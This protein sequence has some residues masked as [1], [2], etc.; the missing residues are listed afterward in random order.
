MAMGPMSK[1][2][3]A[4]NEQAHYEPD[5]DGNNKCIAEPA[6]RGLAIYGLLGDNIFANSVLARGRL[7]G[8]R[9][10]MSSAGLSRVHRPG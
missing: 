6:H 7:I 2:D 4:L 5:E 3:Y 8:G 1:V 10:G 9:F